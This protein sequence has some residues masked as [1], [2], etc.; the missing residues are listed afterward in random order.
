MRTHLFACLLLLTACSGSDDA[1][2]PTDPGG[3]SDTIAP[4]AIDDLQIVSYGADS[5]VVAWTATGDDGDTGTATEYRIGFSSAPITAANW[6]TCTMHPDCPTPTPA[7]SQQDATI[8]TPPTP[9]LYVAMQ[10]VDEAG[11]VSSLSNVVHGHF[12]PGSFEIVQLTLDGNNRYPC[13]DDGFVTWVGWTEDGEEIFI[14]GLH[15]A[16][17][18][19]TRLTYNGG[20][21]M[22][23]SSHGSE[24]I[25]WQGRTGSGDDWE[26]FVYSN[27]AVPRYRAYT[28]NIVPDMFPVLA[29]G[30]DFAWQQGYTMFEEIRY[31]DEAT[32]DEIRISHSCCPTEE[33][34]NTRPAADDGQVV[35]DS[36]LR[37]G[38][39]DRAK[40]YLW[41]GVLREITNDAEG[42]IARVHDLDGSTMVY[43]WSAQ[44][45]HVRVFDGAQMVDL[46]LGYD[47]TLDDGWVAFEAWDGHDW[48]IHLW[49]GS[50]VLQV[51]DNDFED[52]DPS[53]SG[54]RLAWNGRPSGP[55]GTYQI[56]FAK[57]PGR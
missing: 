39:G 38:T 41:N 36:W 55:G 42:R 1:D 43:E 6:A 23:P 50:N 51:T 17:P 21:K 19:P 10:V 22:H 18:S 49:D 45:T 11:N 8:A 3:S 53:L 5:A 57:L 37:S 13:L 16:N 35:F 4:A 34:S 12:D 20:E 44:P 54:D 26:I 27:T 29:G 2:S 48:E 46:G 56:F 14:A 30:G 33:Y 25:V 40:T 32:H 9:D 15:G 24:K 28:D 31:W 7:G 52:Y 47:P